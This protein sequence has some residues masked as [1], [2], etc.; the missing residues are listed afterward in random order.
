MESY[1]GYSLLLAYNP[2]LEH[3]L[4]FSSKLFPRESEGPENL[5][6]KI[7]ICASVIVSWANQAH[8]SD[9][10]LDSPKPLGEVA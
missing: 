3:D 7:C 5:W 10:A 1:Q 6:P 8:F 4:D 9:V 2:E